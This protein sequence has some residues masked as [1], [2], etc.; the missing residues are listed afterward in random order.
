MRLYFVVVVFR[1]TV[2]V[3]PTC[4][5]ID[6]NIIQSNAYVAL[7]EPECPLRLSNRNAISAAKV[8]LKSPTD[9]WD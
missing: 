1:L 9:Q 6:R 4:D 5:M 2:Y 7:H 8:G 3:G